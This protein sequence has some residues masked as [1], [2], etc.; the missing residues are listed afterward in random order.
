MLKRYVAQEMILATKGDGVTAIRDGY[1]TVLADDFKDYSLGRYL[2][3]QIT[4][5][6]RT[7]DG[8]ASDFKS[9][10]SHLEALLGMIAPIPTVASFQNSHC[11]EIA[12]A[13]FVEDVLGYRRLYSKLTL[14]TSENTNA[15]K[16]DGLFVKTDCAPYE[17]LFVEAKSSILPTEATKSKTHRSGILTQ[18]VN[19]LH[20]YHDED[21]R[22]EFSRI[23][24]N[25]QSSFDGNEAEVINA[26]LTPPGPDNLKFIGVSVTNASTVNAGDDDFIL[27]KHC[28]TNFNYYALV[29]TD[30]AEL[31]K[32]AYGRWF[33][34]KAAAA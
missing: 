7:L 19:S 33:K 12:A 27:S 29:V 3:G 8:I 26:D 1:R 18:M 11:G 23:R 25:L 21:P 2:T 24:D 17:Y 16:M 28:N 9:G 32:D 6:Y 15:H 20:K 4:Q 13:Q 5:H 22:F 34:I 30:L 10:N 14:I 31:A